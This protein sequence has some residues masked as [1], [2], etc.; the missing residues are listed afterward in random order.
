[1]W[2]T[3]LD[4]LLQELKAIRSILERAYPEQVITYPEAGEHLERPVSDDELMRRAGKAC[5]YCGRYSETQAGTR[6]ARHLK[7]VQLIEVIVTPDHKTLVAGTRMVLCPR[8]RKL[9][10]HES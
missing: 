9:V 5:E 7:V 1:M 2:N 6:S 10:N 8:C 3:Q 4:Q